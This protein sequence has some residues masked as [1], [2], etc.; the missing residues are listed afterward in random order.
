MST[1]Y[2]KIVKNLV[3]YLLIYLA[4]GGKFEFEIL[5]EFKIEF[6]FEFELNLG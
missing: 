5:I 1:E 3:V 6:E 4:K 2:F